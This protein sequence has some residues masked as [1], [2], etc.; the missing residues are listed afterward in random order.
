MST[1]DTTTLNPGVLGNDLPMSI[2]REFRYSSELGINLTSTL[3]NPQ[4]GRQTFTVTEISTSDP[5]P[6]FFQV[7][8]GYKIVDHRK[9]A[10]EPNT[11]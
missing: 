11:P 8:S 7:P 9:P 2:I 6:A 1:A 10:P 5:D 3:N 4:S